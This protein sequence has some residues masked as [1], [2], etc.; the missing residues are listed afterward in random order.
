[1]R[2]VAW[3]LGGSAL[4]TPTL[5]VCPDVGD[6]QPH[7]GLGVLVEDRHSSGGVLLVE[8]VA[9]GPVV[10]YGQPPAVGLPPRPARPRGLW[11][12]YALT[13]PLIELATPENL[14]IGHVWHVTD[15][16]RQAY[17]A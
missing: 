7:P 3:E 15:A 12:R 9:K 5:P 4:I 14:E 13:G 17:A 6:S 11:P 16:D 10:T 2:S 1:V 8:Q